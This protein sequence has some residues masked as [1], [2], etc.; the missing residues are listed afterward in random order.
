MLKIFFI[1][2]V[3]LGLVLPL[4]A[5]ELNNHIQPQASA[6]DNF[7]LTEF[8]LGA[9][10][11]GFK[12]E[13]QE[14]EQPIQSTD[15]SSGYGFDFSTTLDYDVDLRLSHRNIEYNDFR[16]VDVIHQEM[17]T[18]VELLNHFT[19][20]PVYAVAGVNHFEFEDSQFSLNLGVGYRFAMT[21][22]L[23]SY[24]ESKLYFNVADNHSFFIANIGLTYTF[25]PRKP[26]PIFLPKERNNSALLVSQTAQAKKSQGDDQVVAKY[27]LVERFDNCITTENALK[28]NVVELYFL[29][30]DDTL[31][32]VSSK[33]LSCIGRLLKQQQNTKLLLEGHFHHDDTPTLNLYM[34]RQR[35]LVAKKYLMQ[36][37]DIASERLLIK[38]Q[39]EKR[40]EHELDNNLQPPRVTLT[41]EVFY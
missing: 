31:S 40:P 39:G 20:I 27:P 6:E 19:I 32:Q 7:L 25:S 21:E 23:S 41:I 38:R 11:L 26:Q 33:K 13:N 17:M 3:F 2:L 18:S 12:A 10:A 8:N 9:H 30:A 35:A 37:F 34:P 36:E 5:Q 24:A 14:A 22:H 28:K 16:H 29:D 15:F 1:H 4:Q